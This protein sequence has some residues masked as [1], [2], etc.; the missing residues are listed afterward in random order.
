MLT[1]PDNL[2]IKIISTKYVSKVNF[3]KGKQPAKVS[4]LPKHILDQR[5]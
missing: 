5:W 3:L 1:D 2:W 4:T